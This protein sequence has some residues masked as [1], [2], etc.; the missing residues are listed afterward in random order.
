MLHAVILAGGSGT[1]LWP[2]S[3]THY[4]KQFLQ[5]LGERTLLQQ[6][7]LRL[8]NLIPPERIWIVTGVEQAHI[9]R[10]QLS[11]L[12]G[13]DANKVHI[14]VEPSPKNT[15][16]AIG[17]AAIHARR[18]DSDA[19]LV[20]LPADHW[21]ERQSAFASLLYGAAKLAQREVLVT[22]GIVPD[23]PASG[24][25]YI[26]RGAPF[27]VLRESIPERPVAYKLRLVSYKVRQFVEKPDLP[28]AQR[29][30]L[31]GNYYWN[32]GIFLWKASTILQEIG[33]YLPDLAQGLEE[34][35]HHLD[36]E[37]AEQT[38]ATVF[39]RLKAASIDYG[40]LEKSVRL[41]VVP[42]EIGWSDL[43]DWRTIHRLSPKDARGNVLS[44]NV[45]DI[46]SENSFV[47][48][49]RRKIATIGLKNTVV[50]DA[51]DALLV[52][53]VDRTQEVKTIA[54]Q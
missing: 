34:I 37:F 32:A 9:V 35:E 31:D 13:L 17:L 19:V 20:V 2:L 45:L 21:I 5:L 42:A 53:P 10:E 28:S 43:G 14:L 51:E 22:L 49:K 50:I 4:P 3:R 52:C 44:P 48:S 25:G 18:S 33:L 46:E 15:A 6:T 16:A 38:V 23:Y 27:V 24:Y 30:V 39:A 11:A 54:Y 26:R 36:S 40:I 1:R 41:I 7:A 29:Y 12:F 47:Y 8:G